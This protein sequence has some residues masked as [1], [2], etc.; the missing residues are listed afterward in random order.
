M[1]E[2]VSSIEYVFDSVVVLDRRGTLAA[3]ELARGRVAEQECVICGWRRIGLISMIRGSVPAAV[4]GSQVRR[5]RIAGEYGIAVGGEGT[6]EILAYCPA[7]LAV[8]LATSPGGARHLIA[9][10]LDLRHRLPL[11]W[12]QVLGGRVRSWKAR[13]VAAATRHLSRVQAGVVDVGVVGLIDTMAWS[14]FEAILAATVKT[15]DPVAARAVEERA[16]ARRDVWLARQ[17][18]E[19]VMMLIARGD[20]LDL[21]SFLATVNRVAECLAAEGDTGPVE[22]RRSA[23]VGVL[24]HPGRALALL[25]RHAD[26]S[27][28]DTSP[29]TD[30]APTDPAPTATATTAAA[31]AAET[32]AAETGTARRRGRRP[33]RI[34][35]GRAVV[36]Q[37]AGIGP[38]STTPVGTIRS[39]TR[40]VTGT[41]PSTSTTP[42][43]R[44]T[45]PTRPARPA[46]PGAVGAG[47]GSNSTSTSPTRP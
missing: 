32:A 19:Q 13:Q 38:T 37:V 1:S 28:P 36:I 41:P 14:R 5:R 42:T 9:D 6:P 16:A 12:G 26:P 47:R 29:I 45:R 31:T 4:D 22:V 46:R 18:D 23:A 33:S 40:K 10:A 8:V 44:P 39:P 21:L 17:G 7:E 43:P 20:P 24:A 27:R 34:G 35:S 3:A 15:A 25:R 11:L 2:G 30:P